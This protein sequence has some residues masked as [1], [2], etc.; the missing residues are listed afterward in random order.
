LRGGAERQIEDMS[1][2]QLDRVRGLAAWGGHLL[3]ALSSSTLLIS[4]NAS[5]AVCVPHAIGVPGLNGQPPHWTGAG[6][7]PVKPDIDD[8]RW[9]GATRQ[10]FPFGEMATENEIRAI[11]DG[12][13]IYMSL[14]TLARSGDPLPNF[15][16][17]Y[18]GFAQNAAST[19]KLIK[20]TLTTASTPATGS[21]GG[22]TSSF[23]TKSA[24]GTWTPASP[25][26]G[27]PWIEDAYLWADNTSDEWTINVKAKLANLGVVAPFL[28]FFAFNVQLSTFPP[29]ALAAQPIYPSGSATGA[30]SPTNLAPIVPSAWNQTTL[31]TPGAK[32]TDGITLAWNQIY[33]DNN[34][35]NK[36]NTNA[37]NVFNVTPDWGPE[38]I[39]ADAIQATMRLAHWG[40]VASA[41]AAWTVFAENIHNLANGT[42]KYECGAAGQP[43]CPA[44]NAGEHPHQCMLVELSGTGAQTVHFANDSSWNNMNFGPASKFE[45][46]AEISLVGVPPLAGGT[47][48]RDVY[49]YVKT[50]NM[51]AKVTGNDVGGL[52]KGTMASDQKLARTYKYPRA[53]DVEPHPEISNSRVGSAVSQTDRTLYQQLRE[54]RPTYEVHVYYDTG[55]SIP[56]PGVGNTK[57]LKPMVPFGYFVYHEGPLAGWLHGLEGDG[58]VLTQI[59]P[60]FYHAQMPEGGKV[61]VKTTVTAL[62][63]L[64]GPETV[65]RRWRCAFDVAQSGADATSYYA[66]ALGLLA[67]S[68]AR[69]RGRR[70][71]AV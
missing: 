32:C 71:R 26:G 22:L 55:L 50:K 10:S 70:A 15:D 6:P 11:N 30:F 13:Y 66:G 68:S 44:L 69:R 48:K 43:A 12:T 24:A 23:W 29:P 18:L 8:P 14:R 27:S 47:G 9:L 31:G 4:S 58:F 62:E 7:G 2:G 53:G 61:R 16:A 33:T 56:T 60:D 20:L 63:D 52:P 59:A 17:A 41:D 25:P 38:P 1:Y 37:P 39:A 19:A 57:V 46:P 65:P 51:P 3:L 49:F 40:S 21:S 54:T 5:A 35:T 64:P 36:V 42:I 28:S 34:P 67:L 45:R